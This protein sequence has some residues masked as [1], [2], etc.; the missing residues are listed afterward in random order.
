MSEHHKKRPPARDQ[1]LCWLFQESE[2]ACG[3]SSLHDAMEAMSLSGPGKGCAN[4]YSNRLISRGIVTGN[5]PQDRRESAVGRQRRIMGFMVDCSGAQM[6]ILAMAFGLPKAESAEARAKLGQWPEVAYV[7]TVA[8]VAFEKRAPAGKRDGT[9]ATKA[10]VA[11]DAKRRG[12][13]TFLLGASSG[14]EPEEPRCA[15]GPLQA[16]KTPEVVRMDFQ[17]WLREEADRAL[18]EQVR[19]EAAALVADAFAPFDAS[20]EAWRAT[21]RRVRLPVWETPTQPN[22]WEAL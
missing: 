8:R 5:A 15:L 18:L 6:R 11:E 21:R 3:Q 14:D 17:R 20:R 9:R 7:T 10:S 19:I 4:P 2:S 22:P 13:T 1:D 12:K 16:W